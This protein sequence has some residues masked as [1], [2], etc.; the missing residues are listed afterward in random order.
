MK[1]TGGVLG[2]PVAI[3]TTQ[4][5]ARAKD[6]LPAGRMTQA[7][8]SMGVARADLRGFLADAA[9]VRRMVPSP[10]PN[11]SPI[12][13]H[14]SPRDRSDAILAASTNNTPPPQ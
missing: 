13:A 7:A 9:A 8:D 1:S 3:N 6:L 10:S 5:V 14:E 12:F 11:C 2:D 4:L